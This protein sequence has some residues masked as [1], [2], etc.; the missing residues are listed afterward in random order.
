M[1]RVDGD[2]RRVNVPAQDHA[3]VQ[4]L[5]YDIMNDRQRKD[6]EEF[7]ETD[8]S[9]RFRESRVLGS[10]LLTS[11]EGLVRSSGRFLRSAVDGNAGYGSGIPGHLD[12]A[13]RLGAGNGPNG[14]RQVNHTCRDD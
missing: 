10:M 9:S 14:L 3:E 6:L 4:A 8:F 1:I 13:Q 12:A 7:L 2:I 5:V 11:T